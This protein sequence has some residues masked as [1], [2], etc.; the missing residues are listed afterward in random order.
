MHWKFKDEI[1]FGLYCQCRDKT[2]KFYIAL[3]FK[4]NYTNKRGKG[5]KIIFPTAWNIIN[6]G[7]KSRGK[8]SLLIKKKKKL[9]LLLDKKSFYFLLGENPHKDQN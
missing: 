9:Y 7:P 6:F 2:E 8:R 1:V 4:E 3:S 5:K